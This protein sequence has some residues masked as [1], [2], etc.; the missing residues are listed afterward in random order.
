MGLSASGNLWPHCHSDRTAL[1]EEIRPILRTSLHRIHSWPVPRNWSRRDW[2]CE[3]EGV[4]RVAA[5]E[6]IA[7]YAP[8]NEIAFARFVQ[9]RVISCA[10]TRYR[11]EFLYGLRFSIE[12]EVCASKP[13]DDSEHKHKWPRYT[14]ARVEQPAYIDLKDALDRLSMSQRH[15][16]ERLFW[17]GETEVELAD[18]LGI[19]QAAISKRKQA[20]VSI[21][22]GFLGEK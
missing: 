10:R 13:D 11:Q 2:R 15:L 21:L 7:D 5:W 3:T 16:I 20:V 17:F 22:G 12:L 14:E 9:Q 19:S 8:P 6:A 4:A 1:E 18:A